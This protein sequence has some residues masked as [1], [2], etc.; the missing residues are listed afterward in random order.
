MVN[1]TDFNIIYNKVKLIVTDKEI[2]K[3]NM[4]G[5]VV[6]I[7]EFVEE[8]PE[9]TGNQKRR[10][11]IQTIN[12]MIDNSNCIDTDLK[13]FINIIIYPMID[14]II[15]ASKSQFIINKKKKCCNIM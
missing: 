9:L 1:N 10:I 7:M 12:T 14:S 4:V 5:L 15:L 11:V 6:C 13:D 3:H 8:F 2:D